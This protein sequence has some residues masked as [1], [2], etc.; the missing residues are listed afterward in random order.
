[1]HKETAAT[2]K[3]RNDVAGHGLLAATCIRRASERLALGVFLIVFL[4]SLLG[5]NS[6]ARDSNCPFQT[7]NSLVVE[8]YYGN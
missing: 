1:M 6:S 4:I 5:V 8:I 3:A 7:H 2:N